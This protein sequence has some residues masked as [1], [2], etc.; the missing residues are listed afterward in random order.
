[1][2]NITINSKK[3]EEGT[4]SNSLHDA[5]ITMIP[6]PEKYTTKKGN[7]RRIFL[8]NVDAKILNKHISK[9]SSTIH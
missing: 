4:L 3:T 5:K 9:P 6:K 1:M 7:Y 8:T 2:P